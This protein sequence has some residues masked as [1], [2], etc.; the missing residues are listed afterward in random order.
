MGKFFEVPFSVLLVDDDNNALEMT[1]LILL[2]AGIKHVYILNDSRMV[3]NFLENHSISL[4]ILDLMMPHI[5]GTDLLPLL[6]KDYPHI[7]VIIETAASDV[8]TAVN[9]MK[10]G[11]FDYLVKPVEVSQ[12][13]AAVKI[14]LNCNYM[15]QEL[16]QLKN[17]LLHDRLDNPKAF[18][19]IKTNSRKMRSLFQYVEVIAASPLPVLIT[20][21]TGVGKELFAHSI[22]RL[23]GDNGQFV[24]VNVAGLDDT[25]F[26]DTL[27]G[28]KK[29]AFTGADQGRD[30]LVAKASGG[31]LF[32][33]EIG[34]LNE[35]SQVKLLRLLQENEYYPVGS[36]IAKISTARIILAT[37]LDLERRINEGKFRRDLYYRL[38][39]H[40]MHI[41]PLRE[42]TEDISFLLSI[43][44]NRAAAKMKKTVP[45]CSHELIAALGEY[46]FPGNVRELQSMVFDAVA[47]HRDGE[48]TFEHFPAL[49]CLETKIKP[50][51]KHDLQDKGDG[52]YS[53]YGRL[54]TFR[55]IE[56]YLIVEA[57]KTSGG[58][59]ALAAAVLGVTRQTISNR[60]KSMQ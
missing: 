49:Q 10:I 35:L 41:P 14:A 31:T 39:T 13:V 45:G 20:G 48:L 26:S 56:D 12:L 29:G 59:Q 17:Y 18:S 1:R 25:M 44:I 22:H 15:Q 4:I 37:N 3:A 16:S 28:H 11:A 21:E 53:L 51:P 34:D 52:I 46:S 5:K 30:G 2:D 42:R 19:E 54:P 24:S 9:C 57:M 23:R 58:S 50:V 60:L 8:Q 32:L 33:D 43:F 36:D 38:C 6:R 27:F 55:E 47:R 40:M 7:P